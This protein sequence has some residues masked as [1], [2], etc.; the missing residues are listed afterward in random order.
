MDP[1]LSISSKDKENCSSKLGSFIFQ[2]IPNNS[3][4]AI[5]KLIMTDDC[6]LTT[7]STVSPTQ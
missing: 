6:L 5:I 7:A 3:G 4:L 1:S 2:E